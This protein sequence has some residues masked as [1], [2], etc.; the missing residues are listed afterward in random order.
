MRALTV[1]ITDTFFIPLEFYRK[2]KGAKTGI[3][4]TAP[5]NAKVTVET[6]RDGHEITITEA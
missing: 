4:I 5:F 3:V 1:M 2:I 6:T